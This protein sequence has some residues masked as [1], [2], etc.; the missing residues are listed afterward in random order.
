[1]PAGRF[2]TVC[3]AN[4]FIADQIVGQALRDSV[5]FS[6]VE[7]KML[8]FSEAGSAPPDIMEVNDEFD[9]QYDQAAYEKK[10]AKLIQHLD[11]RLRKDSPAEHDD[12]RSAI[13]YLKRKDHYINVMI[14]KANLRPPWDRLKLFTA[15][16]LV[17]VGLL[18]WTFI[19]QKYGLD[20]YFPD[21]FGKNL[22]LLIY[23]SMIALTV[24]S[25]LVT[26]LFWL[27]KSNRTP[28]FLDKILS[29]LFAD[30]VP[31]KDD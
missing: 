15:G 8:L 25:A 20:R 5:A 17:V 29:K 4:E 10:V 27:F 16:S 21:N 31:A 30:Q 26:Y 12:L 28:R 9:R 2:H 1:M 23:G 6:E 24:L 11:K 22:A 18:I 13:K 7:R 3:E 19:S 14:A